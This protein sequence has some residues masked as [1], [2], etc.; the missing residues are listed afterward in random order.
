MIN[1]GWV[2]IVIF[3]VSGMAWTAVV[4]KWLELRAIS[5]EELSARVERAAAEVGPV[6]RK[7]FDQ[8]MKPMVEAELVALE[9]WMPLIAAGASVLPLLGLLGTVV[10]MVATFGAWAEGGGATS[11]ARLSDGVATALI[12]TEAGL[13]TAVPIFVAYGWLRA[14]IKRAGERMQSRLRRIA[15]ER[16]EAGHV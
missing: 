7:T 15:H 6:N 1:G 11:V 16:R 12:S 10:G 3:I 8:R 5:R 9:S 14:R 13:L 2:V 4:W